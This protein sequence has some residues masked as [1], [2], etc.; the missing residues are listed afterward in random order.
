MRGKTLEEIFEAGRPAEH[1]IADLSNKTIALPSWEKLR[2]EYEPSLHPVMDKA[3]Y[4]DIVDGGKTRAVARIAFNTQK[5]I[6]KRLVGLCFGIP[7][8]VVF[9]PGEDE[10]EKVVAGYLKA[11][12]ERTRIDSVN[13]ERAKQMFASCEMFTL[14]YGVKQKTMEYGFDSDIKLRC[15]T[16]SPMNGDELYPLF[17]AYGDLIAFSIGFKSV[18]NQGTVQYFDTYTANAHYH[19]VNEGNGWQQEDVEEISVGKIPGVYCWRPEPAWED[20]SPQ[21]YEREWKMSRNGNYL[22]KNNIPMVAV[23]ANEDLPFGKE[24]VINEE[25]RNILQLPT[26][27]KV[28]YVTW[29]QATDSLKF[30]VNELKSSVFEQLQI[31]NWS[32][33]DMKAVNTSGEG[34]KQLFIDAHLKVTEESGRIIEMLDREVNVHK[35]FL[36]VMLPEDYAAAI[37]NLKFEVV[38][39]PYAISNENERISNLSLA[40]G[41]KPMMSQRESIQ[42]LGYTDDVDR[43]LKEIAEESMMDIMAE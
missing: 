37:D 24:P 2:K 33:E 35:A 25:D 6:V 42:E 36:K 28:E 8:K 19:W 26:D 12:R 17:D 11:I 43:T 40:N 7:A 27:G 5:L 18:T 30:H 31:P 4:P 41:N 10:K 32:Y 22:D 1:I 29:Q 16:F 34:L 13:I 23:Y 15:R 3:R 9:R 39:T 21:V 38:I 20:V 14:W